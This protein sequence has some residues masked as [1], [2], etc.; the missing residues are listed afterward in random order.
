[1]NT[2]ETE[3]HVTIIGTLYISFSIPLLI[4]AIIAFASVVGGGLLSED[5]EAIG[6]TSVV[7]TSIFMLL[8]AFA[9]PGI[10]CG[11]GILKK[12]SWARVFALILGCMNLFAIPFGTALGIYTIWFFVSDD[13]QAL[14]TSGAK[15]S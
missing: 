10:I 8:T 15:K 14:F 11:I 2:N 4:A 3:K 6:V 13:A 7:G 1:M 9:F 12:K 5:P